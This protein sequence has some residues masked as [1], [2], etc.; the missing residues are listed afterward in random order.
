MSAAL[1]IAQGTAGIK[2]AS[3]T[4]KANAAKSDMLEAGAYGKAGSRHKGLR[5]V[6]PGIE[7]RNCHKRASMCCVYHCVMP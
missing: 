7:S 3:E 5:K 2:S 4:G 1:A 6:R